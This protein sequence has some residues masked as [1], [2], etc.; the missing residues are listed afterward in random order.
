MRCPAIARVFNLKQAPRSAAKVSPKRT[1]RRAARDGAAARL[2]KVGVIKIVVK[3]RRY[4]RVSRL[5]LC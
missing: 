4:G 3:V 5:N 2:H 1:A